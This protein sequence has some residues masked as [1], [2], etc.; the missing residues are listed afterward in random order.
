MGEH[1]AV[2]SN[3]EVQSGPASGVSSSEWG[4]P[5][6]PPPFLMQEFFQSLSSVCICSLWW[7]EEHPP[8]PFLGP[9]SHVVQAWK[10]KMFVH[11]NPP[12]ALASAALLVSW[13]LTYTVLMS[14]WNFLPWIIPEL[15]PLSL[16]A[17]CFR[18]HFLTANEEVWEGSEM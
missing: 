12:L 3:T 15:I 2:L 8:L 1:I 17:H 14:P 10:L 11:R 16:Q 18:R 7:A 9:P 4:P 13:F 5:K 6:P